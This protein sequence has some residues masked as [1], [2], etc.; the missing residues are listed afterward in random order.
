MK[1]SLLRLLR[2][3]GRYVKFTLPEEPVIW[4][5][6]PK[7]GRLQPG[8][9]PG[10]IDDAEQAALLTQKIHTTAADDLVG[11]YQAEGIDPLQKRRIP[12]QVI[13]LRFEPTAEGHQNLFWLL[14]DKGVLL[15]FDPSNLID[16]QIAEIPDDIPEYRLAT[17]DPKF[18][19]SFEPDEPDPNDEAD[20]DE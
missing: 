2:K 17:M 10:T 6:N 9:I 12:E 14:D 18:L 8:L 20:D 16:L 19:A 5:P 7:Q 3:T 15:S 4:V 13:P 1:S 11:I